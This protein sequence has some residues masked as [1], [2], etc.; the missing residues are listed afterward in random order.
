MDIE[1]A[2]YE[3]IYHT[4]VEL[5]KKFRI[6]VIEFHSLGMLFSYGG[7]EIVSLTFKKLLEHFEIVHI[8]PNNCVEPISNGRFD[9]P[10]VMEFTFLRKDRTLVKKT[11]QTFPH[12]L[13]VKN[14]PS[15]P[16]V[17]LPECWRGK[18]SIVD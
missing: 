6:I 8:H 12:A 3:V 16:D 9:V 15:K 7:Y 18:D 10:P 17:V 1:G 11:I 13:D 2:E 4:P 14:F 5:L